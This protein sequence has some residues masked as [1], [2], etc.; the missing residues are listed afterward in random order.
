MSQSFNNSIRR[1]FVP[2][3]CRA[4]TLFAPGSPPEGGS[5]AFSSSEDHNIWRFTV[6]LAMWI[7][8][9]VF[10]FELKIV[11]DVLPVWVASQ[12]QEDLVYSR[13]RW[14]VPGR[15]IWYWQCQWWYYLG[16]SSLFMWA[17][18]KQSY[19]GSAFWGID[20][21]VLE[22]SGMIIH[23]AH[24]VLFLETDLTL[25]LFSGSKQERQ[26]LCAS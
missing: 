2:A 1:N 10:I 24:S 16:H 21:S 12:D 19:S 6:V 20:W 23:P 5:A 17:V 9:S 22:R 25:V 26:I 7:N 14:N 13:Y 3:R 4:L 18:S 11:Q 8:P 15:I